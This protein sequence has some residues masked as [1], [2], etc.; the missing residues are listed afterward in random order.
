MHSK[1]Y[2]QTRSSHK[3][4]P[5]ILGIA[6]LVGVSGLVACG[7]STSDSLPK[8]SI[9]APSGTQ[10][11]TSANAPTNTPSETE[12]KP[13]EQ[14]DVTNSE[15]S[16]LLA[17]DYAN[18]NFT[19]G[20]NEV[21]NWNYHKGKFILETMHIEPQPEYDALVIKFKRLSED[22]SDKVRYSAEYV[23]KAIEVGRG[24][25]INLPGEAIYKI[26]F[27]GMDIPLEPESFP[28][29]LRDETGKQ[30]ITV[31][32]NGPFEGYLEI[33]VG[34][35]TKSPVAITSN[36]AGDEIYVLFKH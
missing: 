27:T 18:L 7:S 32:P 26:S 2:P 10:S 6:S 30:I 11:N 19:D 4:K 20:V 22:T 34:V 12:T 25:E 28:T 35:Q 1:I 8:Q 17:L 21:K 13:K 29:A 3:Y 5:L 36:I 14:P 23:D 9:S 15:D 16:S 33:I 24:H 31:Q